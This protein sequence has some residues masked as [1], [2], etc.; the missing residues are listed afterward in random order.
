IKVEPLVNDRDPRGRDLRL[1]QVG[2]AEGA[3]IETRL[4]DGVF[5]LTSDS[6]GTYYVEYTAANEDGLSAEGLV[7]VDVEARAD[8]AP[9]AVADMALLPPGGSVL[10]DVLAND[11]DPSGGVIAVERVDPPQ[12]LDV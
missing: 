6:P 1:A 12:N 11:V 5:I 8:R 4:D 3:A 2:G 7:R 9:I 10:V